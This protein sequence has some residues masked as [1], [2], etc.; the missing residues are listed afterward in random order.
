MNEDA[1]AQTMASRK[2][3]VAHHFTRELIDNGL[4][5]DQGA[6]GVYGY[7]TK[8]EEVL[9]ALDARL[10]DVGRRPDTEVL[11]F[12][13]VIP[14]TTLERSGYLET[15]PHL[16]GSIHRFSGDESDWQAILNR[17][18]AG[19]NWGDVQELSDVVL[20]PAACYPIYPILS[21]CLP[22][23]G[24]S[25]D[26]SCYCFRHEATSEPGRLKA[27]RVREFVRA[28]NDQECLAWRKDWMNTADHLLGSLGLETTLEPAADP[29]FGPTRRLLQA[30]Q[31]SEGLKFELLVPM[32]RDQGRMSVASFNYHRDHFGSHF[33]IDARAG[34]PAHTACVGFGM[35][36]LVLALLACHGFEPS[37]WPV[38]VRRQ[39]FAE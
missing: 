14:R 38:S 17:V 2:D 20:I 26:S 3:E 37:A 10:T 35:E 11:S 12:P 36:R 1:P 22:S 21:G 31:R 32:G 7:T 16:L 19:E 30:G 15:M 24:R 4:L 5:V 39:L 27:F 9:T 6:A 23:G 33:Q 29:F 8:F 34:A 28:G 25:T 13:P 18:Q